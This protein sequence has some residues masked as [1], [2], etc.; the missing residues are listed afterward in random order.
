MR[1]N[2]VSLAPAYDVMCGGVWESVTK[3]LVHK[4]GDSN[5]GAQLQ[6]KH[7]QQFA[8]ECGL[9]RKQVLDR[10]GTLARS[11]I[12]EIGAAEMA[13]AA[14]LLLRLRRRTSATA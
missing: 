1:S 2:G 4:I 13:M 7:W 3:N 10:V 12:A 11:V 14:S 6:A 9:N 5:R 8:R